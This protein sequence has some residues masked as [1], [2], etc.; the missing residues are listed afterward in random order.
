MSD[1]AKQIILVH[2][3]GDLG[4]LANISANSH[5]PLEEKKPDPPTPGGP[6]ACSTHAMRPFI[7]S[8]PL[9]SYLDLSLC[10]AGH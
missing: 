8:S 7:L 6:G 5:A 2:E 1:T 4:S 9:L 10:Q 3:T